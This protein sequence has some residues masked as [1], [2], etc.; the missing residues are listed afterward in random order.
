MKLSLKTVNAATRI[1]V[2]SFFE[3][4]LRIGSLDALVLAL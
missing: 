1:N 4:I 2:V 3:T